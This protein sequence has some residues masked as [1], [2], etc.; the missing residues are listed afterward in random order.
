MTEHPSRLDYL[1]AIRVQLDAQAL[2][3]LGSS[4]AH[5][6]ASK[7]YPALRTTAAARHLSRSEQRRGYS[8][9]GDAAADRAGRQLRSSMSLSDHELPK[10]AARSKP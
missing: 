3:L 1:D 10:L 5:Y 2:L 6:T 8:A 7:L 9:A 4:E